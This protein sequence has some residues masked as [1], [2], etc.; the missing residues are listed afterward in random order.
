MTSNRKR[1]LAVREQSA[2]TG[3]SYQ[4]ALHT[5]AEKADDPLTNLLN[6]KPEARVRRQIRNAFDY[7]E[8]V[9][10]CE[11]EDASNRIV[12]Q[13]YMN[14][15]EYMGV[16]RFNSRSLTP[17]GHAV[18]AQ[19]D[20]SVPDRHVDVVAVPRGAW[21]IPNLPGIETIDFN[22]ASREF[23]G[24]LQEVLI[25]I[26]AQIEERSRLIQYISIHPEGLKEFRESFYNDVFDRIG[27]NEL[28]L[29]GVVGD[30]WDARVVVDSNVQKDHLHVS[31]I[32]SDSKEKFDGG[33]G[34]DWDEHKRIW[35]IEEPKELYTE[36]VYATQQEACIAAEQ[37]E[38]NAHWC[39]LPKD[40]PELGLHGFIAYN[41]DLKPQRC[42][43]FQ[44]TIF[45]RPLTPDIRVVS[46]EEWIQFAQSEKPQHLFACDDAK[47]RQIGIGSYRL[48]EDGVSV[49]LIRR[50]P[51][52]KIK[53]RDDG[54]GDLL[55]SLKENLQEPTYKSIPLCAAV[56][57]A[58]RQALDSPSQKGAS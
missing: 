49:S 27:N 40:D 31:S 7:M 41:E 19:L 3:L 24:L 23:D 17:Y 54:L 52:T 43:Q 6:P 15:R 39:V 30:L 25:N 58:L 29:Q 5:M 12:Q 21:A 44:W 28:L 14:A 51:M 20:N 4:A 32:P 56:Q 55:M 13:L 16:R 36:Q 1:K 57:G 33:S 42:H 48:A 46:V 10:L 37:L 34:H 26:F 38:R 8:L 50:V 35:Q 53:G 47:A 2:K 18:K 45:S 22:R 11:I 9:G